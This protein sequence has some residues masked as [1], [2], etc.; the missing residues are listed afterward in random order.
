LSLTARSCAA[1][2]T[3]DEGIFGSVTC[4]VSCAVAV[5]AIADNNMAIT[6]RQLILP[7]T[8]LVL[9][10]IIWFDLRKPQSKT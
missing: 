10:P 2:C 1:S 6:T 5:I 9:F 4:R 3:H 8:T 7:A